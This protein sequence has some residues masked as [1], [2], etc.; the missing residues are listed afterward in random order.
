MEYQ[1]F[2][3]ILDEI[4]QQIDSLQ[5]LLT[6]RREAIILMGELSA[7]AGFKFLKIGDHVIPGDEIYEIYTRDGKTFGVWERIIES[8]IVVTRG[9]QIYRRQIKL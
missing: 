3:P 9:S 8:T 4:Q 6:I 1:Q 7:G 5:F 2:L